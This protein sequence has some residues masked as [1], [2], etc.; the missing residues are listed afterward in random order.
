MINNLKWIYC[1]VNTSKTLITF[2]NFF[3]FFYSQ[4]RQGAEMTKP[5]W[6]SRR[7][8]FLTFLC[9]WGNTNRESLSRKF[10]AL[11]RNQIKYFQTGMAAHKELRK[12][13]ILAKKQKQ[14]RPVPNWIRYRTGNTIKGRGFNSFFF[15]EFQ[16]KGWKTEKSS[17]TP[18]D[19]TG[20]VPRLVCKLLEPIS[21]MSLWIQLMTLYIQMCTWFNKNR[22]TLLPVH[23][24]LVEKRWDWKIGTRLQP[25]A[26]L[27][28]F[29]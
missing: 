12:K 19:A 21:P 28:S 27:P 18:R 10:I 20:A 1:G 6:V 11:Q 29:V 3:S 2:F 8:I 26:L 22:A 4:C 5:V 14:N 23:R 16:E 13:L 24:S 9:F 17:T 25:A 15:F 7:K